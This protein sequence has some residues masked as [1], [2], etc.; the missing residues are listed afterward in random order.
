[1]K[2]SNL[3]CL[4]TCC[5]ALKFN[6][7]EIDMKKDKGNPAYIEFFTDDTC[8]EDSAENQYT[9]EKHGLH[10]GEAVQV[11]LCYRLEKWNLKEDKKSQRD[12]EDTTYTNLAIKFTCA[13]GAITQQT[14]GSDADCEAGNP[15]VSTNVYSGAAAG[16]E[17]LWEA[18][19]GTPLCK[20][21][22]TDQGNEIFVALARFGIDDDADWDTD[23][24]AAY[25]D[26]K[27]LDQQA[28]P[29]NYQQADGRQASANVADKKARDLSCKAAVAGAATVAGKLAVEGT[30]G[31]DTQCIA[32]NNPD[33]TCSCNSWVMGA[34]LKVNAGNCVTD[35]VWG[36]AQGNLGTENTGGECTGVDQ[37]RQFLPLAPLSQQQGY[38]CTVGGSASAALRGQGDVANMFVATVGPEENCAADFS[39]LPGPQKC[40][41]A[42]QQCEQVVNENAKCKILAEPDVT[43]KTLCALSPFQCAQTNTAQHVATDVTET[44]HEGKATIRYTKRHFSPPTDATCWAR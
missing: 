44:M 36:I 41:A 26:T 27:P 12:V 2:V 13:L 30:V 4:L 10:Q 14:F 23:C 25:D 11:D 42:A 33:I 5:Q 7:P 34:H 1:M 35:T 24:L 20:V 9:L 22:P 29:I 31:P 32:A 43:M 40:I 6:T 16:A 3:F 39:H 21:E 15:A 28:C 17:V 37:P 38:T 19:A 18:T 8:D